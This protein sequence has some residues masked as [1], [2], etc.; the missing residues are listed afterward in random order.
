M[1]LIAR[2]LITSDF[3]FYCCK[4]ISLNELKMNRQDVNFMTFLKTK[5]ERIFPGT[6]LAP[7]L[8]RHL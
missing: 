7:S 5:L 3:Y 2:G 8:F 6:R 1:F 4:F